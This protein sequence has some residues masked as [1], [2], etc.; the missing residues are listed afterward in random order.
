M[1]PRGQCEIFSTRELIRSEGSSGEVCFFLGAGV[2][3]LDMKKL[4]PF[5]VVGVVGFVMLRSS[6]AGPKITPA[7][8][9]EKVGAGTAVLIDVREPGE[10]SG[11]VVEG[12]MLLPLSDLQGDRV[13]WAKPLA[14]AQGREL[15]V[16]C[17]SGKRSG[18][19]AGILEKEGWTVWNAGGFS[20]WVSDGQKVKKP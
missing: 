3:W 5:L 17:R 19:V 16:Y 13:M 9:M 7:E 15:V 4:I 11:G 1:L 12:A 8:A 6:F 18:I 10:W 20:S 14:D 2:G